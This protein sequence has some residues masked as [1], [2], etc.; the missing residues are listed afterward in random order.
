MASEEPDDNT[1]ASR[2]LLTIS[3]RD[4]ENSPGYSEFLY[5]CG[6]RWTT[7]PADPGTRFQA[8]NGMLLKI[9]YLGVE[10]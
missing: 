2:N 1:S 3:K 9:F 4:P 10:K 6:N 5:L 8:M 7:P